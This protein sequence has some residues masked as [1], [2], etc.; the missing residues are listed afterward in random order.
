MCSSSGFPAASSSTLPG[1]REE[2]MRASIVQTVLMP[3]PPA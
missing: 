1:R 3:A 2:V